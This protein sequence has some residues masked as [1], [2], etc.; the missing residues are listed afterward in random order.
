MT[1]MNRPLFLRLI[2]FNCWMQAVLLLIGVT[3][4]FPQTISGSGADPFVHDKFLRIHRLL[5]TQHIALQSGVHEVTEASPAQLVFDEDWRRLQA[6]RPTQRRFLR[7]AGELSLLLI[8]GTIWY[9]SDQDFNSPDWDLDP[10]LDS[11]WQAIK[12]DAVRFDSNEFKT[13]V[14]NHPFTGAAYYMVAR[15]NGYTFLESFLFTLAAS[16]VWE[17]FIEYLEQVS[18]NDQAFSPVGGTVVGE[19]L[20]QLGEFFTTSADNRTNG[21]LKWVFGA[22]QNYHRWRDGNT[23]THA[24]SVD[25][26]GFR[27]DIWHQ[28]GLFS[29]VGT[30]DHNV[31]GE[32]GLESQIIALPGYGTREGDVSSFLNG[33][34]FTQMRLRTSFSGTGLQDLS[35]LMKVMFMGYFRQHLTRMQG[36]ALNGYSL[37]IGPTSAFELHQHDWL[38]PSIDDA[39]GIVNIL[40]PS[41]DLAYYRAALR[42]RLT[43]DVY[44]DFAAVRAFAIDAFKEVGS[45]ESAKLVLRENDYY[46]ALG[47]TAR[48]RAALSYDHLQLGVSGR[49]SYYDSI[50]GLDR[51]EEEIINDVETTDEIASVRTWLSYDL[52]ADLIKIAFS[53]ERLWRSGTAS[54]GTIRASESDSEDRFL[55]SL[56]FLF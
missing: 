44:G 31:I 20:Y 3:A 29:G 5:N 27:N 17:Y 33:T 19:V 39:Y 26:F 14:V 35:L 38:E 25:R 6:E 47:V 7:T 56:S 53:Y 12:G 9:W 55:G 15:S 40:G 45:V 52:A 1:F 22:A 21:I 34:L 18:I 36:G 37:F 4:A 46:F 11:L 16:S 49:Y 41:V 24:T 48:A 8:G 51:K 32:L 10:T 30:A 43:M 50:E 23:A 42:L 54:S 13:N 28:F 2:I